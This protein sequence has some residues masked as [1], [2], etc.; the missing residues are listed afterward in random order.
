[1]NKLVGLWKSGVKGKAVGI[2]CGAMVLLVLL[3]S[4]CGGSNGGNVRALFAKAKEA[5]KAG[6][7]NFFGFYTGMPMEDAKALA[8]HYG[9]DIEEEYSYGLLGMMDV[10]GMLP[11]HTLEEDI[12]THEVYRMRFSLDKVR[13]ITKERRRKPRTVPRKQRKSARRKSRRRYALSTN[14]LTE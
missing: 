12:E 9:L 1:M 4:G 8:E 6:N 10:M 3:Q 14:G 5:E 13:K 7:I 11:K 2:V